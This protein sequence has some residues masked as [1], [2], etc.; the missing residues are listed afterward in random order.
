MNVVGL[1]NEPT[2]KLDSV[3]AQAQALASGATSA[4]ALTE[5]YLAAIAARNPGINAFWHVARESALAQSHA[6]DTRRAQG[7]ALG[8]LDGI[9]VGVKDNIAVAQMPLTAGMATRKAAIAEHDAHVV[10]A[11][12]AA[13]AILLGK[14]SLH[15]GALGADNNNPHFGACH[16]PWRSGFTP[17]GSSGGSGAAVAASLCAAS[18]GTDTMGSVRIPAAYCGVIGFKPSFGQFSQRGLVP[19]C[20]RLDH[21]GVLVTHAHDL[22]PLFHVLSAPD[23]QDPYFR[24]PLRDA[25]E[26]HHEKTRHGALRL[27]VLADL[28]AYGVDASVSAVFLRAVARIAAAVH[29]ASAQALEVFE[30]SLGEWPFGQDR[31]AGLLAAEAEM[32]QF[33]AEDLA[34]CPELFSPQLLAMLR[35]GQH[36]SAPDLAAALHRIEVAGLRARNLFVAHN[37]EFFITPTTPQ[38]AFAFGEPVP[39]N[40]ADLTSMAN[41]GGLPA[42]SLPCGLANNGLPVG[43]QILARPGADRALIAL[44]ERLAEVV[45]G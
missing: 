41:F 42:L 21:V 40:Q 34:R 32:A 35:F 17:G 29:P 8:P 37:V 1:A 7:R 11:L 36:K 30:V 19:A 9:T 3:C 4:I 16:N 45:R 23:S 44:A 25:L 38:T 10:S 39:A 43:L 14:L 33:H 27:G 13:G 24:A 18:L 12:K 2:G 5:Q 22:A 28:A 20:R 6:S 15:E 26:T 31:R